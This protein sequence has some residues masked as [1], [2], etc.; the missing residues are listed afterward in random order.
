MA[1]P[2]RD[3]LAGPR[4]GLKRQESA[5]AMSHAGHNER[6]YFCARRRRRHSGRIRHVNFRRG[7]DSQLLIYQ[8]F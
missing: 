5:H 6:Q 1:E 7:D 3:A 2:V 4:R 8:T